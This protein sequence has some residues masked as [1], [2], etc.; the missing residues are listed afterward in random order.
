[1]SIASE[2]TRLQGCKSDIRTAL[3]NK[4]VTSASTHNMADFATDISNITAGGATITVTYDSSFYNKTITCSNGSKTYTKTTTSS[5]S[6]EFSVS[7]EGTWTI[8]CNGV[9]RTVNVV[10][11]YSTQMTITKTITVYSAAN[12][13]VSFTDAAGSK[14]VTTNSSGQGS[15]S[16]TFIPNQS[17]TF[18]STVAKNPNNLSA[19]YSKTITITESTTS[20]SVMPDGVVIYW[21]GYNKY[22]WTQSGWQNNG[23]T[24]AQTGSTATFNTNNM[25]LYNATEYPLMYGLSSAIDLSAQTEAHIIYKS[26]STMYNAQFASLNNTKNY[27]SGGLDLTTST[28]DK[29]ISGAQT[30][31]SNIYPLF[32]FWYAST[33]GHKAQRVYVSAI[34]YD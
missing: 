9:S 20:V 15:V 23:S 18:T 29:H 32:R 1:M 14:T 8:T 13:T 16:I 25:E 4:G 5:G 19:N 17:I 27:T 7:D 30:L 28:S 26:S 2:I 33:A 34:W 24:S 22:P 31:T 3:V 10:L 11:N 21:W 12:D 6:T